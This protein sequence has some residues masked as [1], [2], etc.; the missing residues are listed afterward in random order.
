MQPHGDQAPAS[1]SCFLLRTAPGAKV[2]PGGRCREPHSEPPSTH[3][4]ARTWLCDAAP[5]A[6]PGSTGCPAKAAGSRAT[7]FQGH[8][9]FLSTSSELVERNCI[10]LESLTNCLFLSLPPCLSPI[11]SFL[12]LLF[13]SAET[14]PV[15]SPCPAPS[16]PQWWLPC[17][18]TLASP[19][20]PPPRPG[21]GWP[22]ADGSVGIWSP[23]RDRHLPLL[24]LGG[25]RGALHE[26][27]LL[28]EAATLLHSSGDWHPLLQRPLPAHPRG[29]ASP[30]PSL[31]SARPPG[32]AGTGGGPST[33]MESRKRS[34]PFGKR[35]EGLGRARGGEAA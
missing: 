3:H 7:E 20:P 14:F 28:Q 10:R 23:L 17:S 18:G 35:S 1:C 22:P 33:S 5:P 25:Q 6:P 13:V 11:F 32:T 4:P 24:P 12:L 26:E 31:R 21:W 30:G 2:R 16:S 34:F 8:R 27:D 15:A 19:A 9:E 29:M